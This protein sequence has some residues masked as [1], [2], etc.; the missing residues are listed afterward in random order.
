MM[1]Q[2]DG[3]IFVISKKSLVKKAEHGIP[4]PGSVD[5]TGGRFH[6]GQQ[7]SRHNTLGRW[8]QAGAPSVGL[9]EKLR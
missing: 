2:A 7:A 4:L 6:L 5:D 1:I 3:F 8:I 9:G